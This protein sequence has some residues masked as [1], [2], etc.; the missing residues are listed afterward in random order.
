MTSPLFRH[1][2]RGLYSDFDL[3]MKLWSFM[4]E[5]WV[6]GSQKI[7]L[8]CTGEVV[9]K[10]TYLDESNIIEVKWPII[11]IVGPNAYLCT[12]RLDA[13]QLYVLEEVY[14]FPFSNSLFEIRY[15]GI[16]STE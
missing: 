12:M 10:A 15:G 13:K 16:N 5:T 1:Q 8:H 9:K 2:Y 7:L 3:Q 11:Q 14:A 4:L 6:G